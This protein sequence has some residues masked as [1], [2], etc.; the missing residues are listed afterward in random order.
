[1]RYASAQKM[2]DYYISQTDNTLHM[3]QIYE[4]KYTFFITHSRVYTVRNVFDTH[5]MMI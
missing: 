5:N 1:M 2:L 3:A 4:I